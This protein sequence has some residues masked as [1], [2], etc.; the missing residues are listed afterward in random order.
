MKDYHFEVLMD[1][2]KETIE[3]VRERR[4]IMSPRTS[5][6]LV[7]CSSKERDEIARIMEAENMLIATKEA[8]G[9]YEFRIT[10]PKK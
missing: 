9:G 3:D 2:V 10:Y 4:M 8:R 6:I 5:I 7:P 1:V